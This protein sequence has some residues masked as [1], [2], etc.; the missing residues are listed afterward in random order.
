MFFTSEC[1]ENLPEPTFPGRRRFTLQQKLQIVNQVECIRTIGGTLNGFCSDMGYD[2]SMIRRWSRNV[3][4]LRKAVE[5]LPANSSRLGARGCRFS[6]PDEIE[7]HLLDFVAERRDNDQKVTVNMM[8]AEWKRQD[9]ASILTLS[10]H[11]IRQRVYR[12]LKRNSLAFRR[13]TH[14]AQGS[15]FVAK[16]ASDF[17]E[18]VRKKAKFFQV[19]DEA[20]ANFDET[21]VYFAPDTSSTIDWRGSRTVSVNKAQSSSRLTAMIGCTKTGYKFPPYIIFKG[22]WLRVS[23]FPLVTDTFFFRH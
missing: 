22:K 20:I 19:P 9:P 10:K 13:V 15:R 16:V 12:L 11:A 17:Q 6:H 1:V 21:N 5:R 14:Q 4:A 7:E 2:P 8:V 3:D 18:Y 23:L